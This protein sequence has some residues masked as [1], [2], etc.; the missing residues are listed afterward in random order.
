M[1]LCALNR[2]G[3]RS[4]SLRMSVGSAG[5]VVREVGRAD[6]RPSRW[7]QEDRMAGLECDRFE[8]LKVCD[9]GQ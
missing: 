4:L 8:L 5:R 1:A 9:S 7:F 2:W 6:T 3:P